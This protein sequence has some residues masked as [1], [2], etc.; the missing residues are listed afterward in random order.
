MTI[1]GAKMDIDLPVPLDSDVTT[2]HLPSNRPPDTK[3]SVLPSAPSM[4][5]EPAHWD[6]Q[7]HWRP[8][9]VL[10]QEP[11]GRRPPSFPSSHTLSGSDFTT[12]G[13]T[14]QSSGRRGQ[15]ISLKRSSEPAYPRI[16]S[17]PPAPQIALPKSHNST[18]MKGAIA[19]N[20]GGVGT[21]LVVSERERERS[22]AYR[23][24]TVLGVSDDT[25]TVPTP[26]DSEG[27]F[28]LV[29]HPGS[30]F[31][32]VGR[33]EDGIPKVI[34]HFIARRIDAKGLL[35]SL[36]KT[37]G[38]EGLVDISIEELSK[39]VG[40][41]EGW[42]DEGEGW[43]ADGVM[44]GWKAESANRETTEPVDEKTN[45]G[46]SINSVRS[47]PMEVDSGPKSASP[48]SPTS[49]TS[50]IEKLDDHNP[51]F[52]TL[53]VDMPSYDPI[54]SELHTHL[55]N[56]VRD[57]RASGVQGAQEKVTAANAKAV[58]DFT[59][60]AEL[61]DRRAVAWTPWGIGINDDG[62]VV[63]ERQA[64]GAKYPGSSSERGDPPD[65]LVGIAALNLPQFSLPRHRDAAFQA[66]YVALTSENPEDRL[67]GV[68]PIYVL[69][70]PVRHGTLNAT[71]Y[72]SL[73]HLQADID[74]I[75][76]HAVK[77]LDS[78]IS[79]IREYNAV[80][81]VPDKCDKLYVQTVI[82]V[83]TNMGFSGI[84]CVQESAAA[85]FGAGFGSETCL[86]DIGAEKTSVSCVEEGTVIASSRIN[87]KYGSDDVTWYL[88]HLLWAS[89]FPY[90]A[91]DPR[92]SLSDFLHV[93]E[94]VKET[95]VNMDFGEL[96]STRNMSVEVRSPGREAR[97]WTVRW[98]DEGILSVMIFFY[99]NIINH[100]K[101]LR[102]LLYPRYFSST[103]FTLTR[104][105]DQRFAVLPHLPPPSVDIVSL[106]EWI[107]GVDKYPPGTPQ[108]LE[109]VLMQVR[110]AYSRSKKRRIS[111]KRTDSDTGNLNLGEN[112]PKSFDAVKNENDADGGASEDI[113]T[114]ESPKSNGPAHPHVS[115][116]QIDFLIEA[117]GP[118]DLAI[119]QSLLYYYNT[120]AKTNASGDS[121]YIPDPTLA[122]KVDMPAA[123]PLS[124]ESAIPLH[125]VAD[126]KLRQMASTVLL[127]GDG[128]Q[129]SHLSDTIQE[130]VQLRLNELI[131]VHAP[132]LYWG[133]PLL[134][135]EDWDREQ[136]RLQASIA[137]ESKGG[138]VKEGVAAQSSSEI[139]SQ[140]ASSKDATTSSLNI[141]DIKTPSG[142][143][144]V[145]SLSGSATSRPHARGKERGRSRGR[146]GKDSGRGSTGGNRSSKSSASGAASKPP[147]IL[148]PPKVIIIY[149]PP[150][151]IPPGQLI[152]KGAS[153]LARLDVAR[154]MWVGRSELEK[155]GVAKISQTKWG[156]PW[157][158][159]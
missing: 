34:H 32:R 88:S 136:Q 107:L 26:G 22:R 120:V 43:H 3:T 122:A 93:V 100:R 66:L 158:P 102:G 112:D 111:T 8:P 145:D 137:G 79:K 80:I 12:I 147:V 39:M 23:L 153:V 9:D 57:L 40:W 60:I 150:R 86:V 62:T 19:G 91:F 25:T 31:L 14:S 50:P 42:E 5:I 27:E 45:G 131:A 119:A 89:H 70:R 30:R 134:K 152:W 84:L 71:S 78:R 108:T 16:T 2:P 55:R 48:T 135:Q 149:P 44:A 41:S 115:P 11:L 126:E 113:K 61:S 76:R 96:I 124:G 10:A 74:F 77:Q 144:H 121:T 46:T 4:A 33:A 15:G 69:R 143:E 125:P 83:A 20:A 101:K 155:A 54:L 90:R 98:W 105:D 17:I 82:S 151:E 132:H 18:F 56:R 65:V 106:D 138:S 64:V 109:E 95:Y 68:P 104:A 35:T 99:P 52:P 127:A 159:Q 13:K 140:G 75:W 1:S 110:D 123:Q 28:T 21:Y 7:L 156:I 118:L 67:A 139:E 59:R 114:P 29:F 53:A 73:A 58:D 103:P 51:E 6:S 47:D 92:R 141:S 49:P 63:G 142:V 94:Q 85:C 157:D 130:R 38:R 97:V 133:V 116:K 154:E 129:I 81:V 36:R 72:S 128:T 24:G 87:L 117:Q 148:G 146:S 37:H